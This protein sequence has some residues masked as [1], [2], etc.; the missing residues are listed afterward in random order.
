MA[1]LLC[2][3]LL[4]VNWKLQP[5]IKMQWMMKSFFSKIYV[6]ICHLFT[7]SS[8]VCIGF[9]FCTRRRQWF[10]SRRIEI[11]RRSSIC[12]AVGWRS[13]KQPTPKKHFLVSQISPCVAMWR[14][15]VP[16][17]SRR[18]VDSQTGVCRG[19]GTTSSR[20]SGSGGGECSVR[21]H[22]VVDVDACVVGWCGWTCQ[23]RDKESWSCV[24]CTCQERSFLRCVF[25]MIG[26]FQL[27]GLHCSLSI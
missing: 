11:T 15:V 27:I 1:H 16:R 25:E 17:W 13:W 20:G 24:A 9:D 22:D 26:S 12:I 19:R 8:V 14:C 6:Y 3:V 7:F 5:L 4:Q 23:T 10:E 2:C 18:I 21:D